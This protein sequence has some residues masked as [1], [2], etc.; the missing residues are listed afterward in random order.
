MTPTLRRI[1][2]GFPTD[3]SHRRPYNLPSGAG[4]LGP[5]YVEWDPGH[6]VFGEDWERGRRDADG[7]L[8][9]AVGYH[10]IRIA[11]FSLHLNASLGR[12]GGTQLRDRFIA[13]ARWLRD[14]QCR[15]GEV[16][17]LYAFGFPWTKYGVDA[18]WTS[19]MAQGEAISVLL[20]AER[21][22]AGQ[23]FGDAACRAAEPF[24]ATIEVGG[25]VW[26]NGSVAFLEEV[27][28]PHSAH[29][30]NGCIF[31]L[32]GLWELHAERGQAWEERLIACVRDTILHWLPLY[33]T[34]WWSR[35]S[36]MRTPSGR[37]HVATLKYHAFHIAQLRVLAAMFDEPRF[38]RTA[39]Q[40]EGYID[41]GGAR[42]RLL[43]DA[44]LSL[45]SRARTEDT[46]DGGSRADVA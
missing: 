5:Y 26:K 42:R 27:A 44:A 24:K 34:G 40:W 23:G 46:V 16:D 45:Y 20:R 13:Q 12:E 39:D 18:G 38:A 29:I 31:A 35:Y 41:D 11:Q 8:R 3:W 33:D 14:N 37:P 30:L 1:A 7:V 6:G 17:G 25:V 43:L 4:G 19:A 15:R 10:P 2:L 28:A 22:H 36:L 9:D 32:W 21:V